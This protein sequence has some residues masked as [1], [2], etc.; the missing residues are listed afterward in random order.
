MNYNYDYLVSEIIRGNYQNVYFS[1]VLFHIWALLGV[2]R[3]N[4]KTAVKHYFFKNPFFEADKAAE[5]IVFAN[6]G[7]VFYAMSMNADDRK[8]EVNVVVNNLRKVDNIALSVKTIAQGQYSKELKVYFENNNEIV[9][10]NDDVNHS[11]ED[12]VDS[13]IDKIAQFIFQF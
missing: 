11:W 4:H 7:R 5:V 2:D 9:L 3:N 13:E 1:R 6:N 12:Q 10:R 8:K